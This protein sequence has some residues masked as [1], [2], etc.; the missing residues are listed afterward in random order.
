[1]SNVEKTPGV[2]NIPMKRITPPSMSE[3]DD[4]I[5]EARR[6]GTTD[7]HEA[8]GCGGCNRAVRA[9]LMKVVVD[10]NVLISGVFFGGVP[11]R[12][13]EAWRDR[14]I[15]LVVS[16]EI[17]EEYR[18]VGEM[19][20]QQFDGISLGPFLVLLVTHAK[21][22][23][24]SPLKR[25]ISRDL[26]DD[27]FIACAVVGECRHIISGDKDLLDL[28]TFRKIRIALHANSW[29]KSSDGLKVDS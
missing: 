19:L 28:G 18:R 29:I 5:D 21:I 11:R 27:K 7:R 6:P 12:V 8:V 26:E 16:P 14:K 20:E 9:R 15:E 13:L 17:L 4:I 23:K 2:R 1:M 25:Q 10:P 3:Y 22:V 24:P